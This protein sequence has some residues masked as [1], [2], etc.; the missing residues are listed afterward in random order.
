MPLHSDKKKESSIHTD[1]L[2]YWK[3]NLEK[4][5]LHD[6]AEGRPRENTIITKFYQSGVTALQ[7][8]H[9]TLSEVFWFQHTSLTAAFEK[10][11][12]HT[13]HQST[14]R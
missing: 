9:S 11:S 2:S 10:E 13:Y 5:K 3:V 6:S 12:L 1:Y 14:N 4:K 8:K 7:M